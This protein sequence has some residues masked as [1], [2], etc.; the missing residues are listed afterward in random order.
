MQQRRLA[1]PQDGLELCR[2]FGLDAA[3]RRP[4]RLGGAEWNRS[5]GKVFLYPLGVFLVS[6]SLLVLVVLCFVT[7]RAESWALMFFRSG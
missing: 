7:H 1:A 3:D 2:R 5:L 4:T 6:A